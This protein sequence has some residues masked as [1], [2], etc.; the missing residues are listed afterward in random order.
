[1]DGLPGWDAAH[2]FPVPD[3]VE[4]RSRPSERWSIIDRMVD[5]RKPGVHTSSCDRGDYAAGMARSAKDVAAAIRERLP[6]VPTKKL[7]KLLYYAQ[8][9][10][11]ATFHQT[12]FVESVSADD[13][14]PV[15]GQLWYAEKNDV[16]AAPP[17]DLD[18]AQ[19]N[20]V[21]YVISRY[22]GLS[23]RDLEILSHGERP[24]QRANQGR[25]PGTSAR[26]EP[27]WLEEYFLEPDEDQLTL[28]PAEI[29]AW[30]SGADRRLSD[31]GH[32]DDISEIRA[33]LRALA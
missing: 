28:D 22:G 18:E 32:P 33:R 2:A 29:A 17:A 7:H 31:D 30:L 11:L 24:W 8:G 14:G 16:P 6:S 25:E 20:T 26:I 27:E 4:Q 21:G 13:M 10:H 3:V 5:R 23:G 15:V 19:L 1:M 12:L 9:H